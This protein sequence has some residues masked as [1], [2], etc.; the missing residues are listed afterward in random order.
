MCKYFQVCEAQENMLFIFLSYSPL[1]LVG[2]VYGMRPHRALKSPEYRLG[3]APPQSREG[4]FVNIT[5]ASP[6]SNLQAIYAHRSYISRPIS[7]Y[8]EIAET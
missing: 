3:H 1:Y 4:C 6:K 5:L 2:N 8:A 7:T